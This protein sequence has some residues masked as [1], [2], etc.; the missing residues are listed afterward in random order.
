MTS[1]LF[2]IAFLRLL[3]AGS[4]AGGGEDPG[5]FFKNLMGGAGSKK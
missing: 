5:A 2:Y 3:G 4:A 1:K